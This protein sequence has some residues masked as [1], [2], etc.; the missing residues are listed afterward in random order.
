MTKEEWIR[1]KRRKKMALVFTTTSLLM[2]I[3]FF[4]VILIA[5]IWVDRF[6]SNN[7]GKE[8]ITEALQNGTVVQLNYLTPNAYSR[9]QLPLKRIKGVVVHYTANPGTSAEN[10]R[11]YF[12]GLAQKKTTYASSHYIVGLEGEILQ[13]IPLTEEAYASNDRNEDTIAIEC[14]HPD[15][16]GEF[17]E[18]T[19]DSLVS[20]T[21][22]LCVEFHLEEEDIIR[23]Y[24][25]TGKLCPKYYVEHEEDWK[26]FKKE[27]MKTVKQIKT[28]AE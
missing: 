14:C 4:S 25:I 10:N 21:A 16:T 8:T 2:I 9:P 19:Y 15:D 18:M 6:G 7:S 12:E 24:D 22:A 5:E 11:S 1:K 26:A 17:N 27:V 28:A 23:H 20:L 3:L 13:C